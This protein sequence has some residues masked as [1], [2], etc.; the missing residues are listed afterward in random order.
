MDD[1]L[2]RALEHDQAIHRA[3]LRETLALAELALV[4]AELLLLSPQPGPSSFPADFTPTAQA[5]G[6]P[7][8]LSRSDT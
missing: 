7:S 4:H 6:R 1:E 8:G 3:V 5:D 2:R